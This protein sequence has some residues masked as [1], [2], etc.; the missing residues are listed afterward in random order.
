LS[1]KLSAFGAWGRGSAGAWEHLV[2]VLVLILLLVIEKN[3]FFDRINGM[4]EIRYPVHPVYPVE[5]SPLPLSIAS[6][7]PP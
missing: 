5:N 3:Y 4:G 6:A 2:L 7:C 1:K